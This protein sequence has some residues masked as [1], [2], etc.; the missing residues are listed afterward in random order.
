MPVGLIDPIPN[1]RDRLADQVSVQN[2]RLADDIA[3]L[4]R[5]NDSGGTPESG[6]TLMQSTILCC[7]AMQ[8]RLDLFLETLKDVLKGSMIVKSEI[9]AVELKELVAEFFRPDDSFMK[10]QLSH[11]VAAIG[12]PDVVDKLHIKVDRTRAHV[13]TRLGVE[14]DILCRRLAKKKAMFWQSTSFAK[15][16]LVAEI[17]CSLATMWYA[18]LWI[19]SPTSSISVQMIISGSLVFLLGRFRRYILANY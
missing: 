17:S 15:G 5:D 8:D 11:V 18:Y 2:L 3:A 16:V 10:D 4:I 1:A 7:E 13:L 9:G 14:I 19:H 12:A 6:K